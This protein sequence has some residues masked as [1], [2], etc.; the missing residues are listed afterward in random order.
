MPPYNHFM[1]R[2]ILLGMVAIMLLVPP[3][4]SHAKTGSKP[5]AAASPYEVIA[6]VNRLRAA[7]GVPAYT[8][9]S[10]L[11]ST[12]QNQADYMAATGSVS[13]TGAGGSSV[14]D[15]LLAAGYP[16]AG[17]LS[18]GGFRSENITAGSETMSAQT[19]VDQWAGDSV[20]LTT[21]IS[22]DLTEIGAGI[23]VSNGR[24]YFVIDCARPTTSEVIQGGGTPVE[25]GTVTAAG[26]AGVVIPVVVSTPNPN[27]DLIHEV[28]A[29][30]SLWQIAIAY[31]TKIDEIKRLNGLYGNDIYPGTKLLI[32]Q[33]VILT[34]PLAATAT[35]MEAVAVSTS[36]GAIA[37]TVV[38]PTSMPTF[39]KTSA[40]TSSKTIT[41]SVLG[42]LVLALIGGWLFAILGNSKK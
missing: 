41:T 2:R 19:A 17:Q 16:L 23:S 20:H 39:A 7:Y 4:V 24:A 6:A 28:K 8:I 40:Q 29:G 32:R 37:A 12:A 42:I 35:A 3:S 21:M 11:M 9:S 18:L 33:G 22:P 34:P 14:T 30:Q 36:V 25:G 13:H 26:G 1:L 10:I 27:G 15:R 38:P 5:Q 31:N